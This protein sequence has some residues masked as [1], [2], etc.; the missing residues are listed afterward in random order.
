MQMPM[1]MWKALQAL[2][3]KPA[4]DARLQAVQDA[5]DDYDA[6]ATA[7]GITWETEEM[8]QL[9]TDHENALREASLWAR[10]RDAGWI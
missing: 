5:M 3:H 10:A 1:P 9:N 2:V 8:T 4:A 7:A 6:R